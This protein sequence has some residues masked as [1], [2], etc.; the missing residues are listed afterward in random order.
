MVALHEQMS[1]RL[2]SECTCSEQLAGEC[3][4]RAYG[5]MMLSDDTIVHADTEAVEALRGPAE[6]WDGDQA[7]ELHDSAVS[8]T[9]HKYWEFLE[10]LSAGH[11]GDTHHY[12]V[13]RRAEDG[14]V[15]WIQA[16]IHSMHTSAGQLLHMWHVRDITSA[17]RCLEMSQTPNEGDLMLSLEDDGLPHSALLTQVPDVCSSSDP[18]VRSQLASILSAVVAAETFAVLHLTSFGAVDTVFPRRMFGW[19][20]NDLLDRSFISLLCPEDRVFF[21]RA[22]RRCHRD[23]IPQRLVLKLAS[24]FVPSTALYVDCDVT[25]LMPEAVQQPVLIVRATDLPSQP[26]RSDTLCRQSSAHVVRRVQMDCASVQATEVASPVGT[27]CVENCTDSAVGKVSGL[28]LPP[29]PGSERMLASL[30]DAT[31]FVPATCCPPSIVA[32]PTLVETTLEPT[33]E[34]TVEPASQLLGLY[35]GIGQALAAISISKGPEPTTRP[36]CNSAQQ[37]QPPFCLPTSICT[38]LVSP[39]LPVRTN[40]ETTIVALNVEASNRACI[41]I[42]M[43][44]IFNAQVMLPLTIANRSKAHTGFSAETA[45]GQFSP[46]STTLTSMLERFSSSLDMSRSNSTQSLC[47]ESP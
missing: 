20:E 29:S 43:C 26:G 42:P 27:Q 16:C 18:N 21:C 13:I 44:E 39:T 5:V 32:A 40:T 15:C 23:G 17:A 33:V 7:R 8:G 34:Q 38:G 4:L 19:S 1:A 36:I 10:R 12:F 41:D 22:L 45:Y 30:D 46:A 28:S 11:D 3:H 2:R 35:G 25:V 47:A 14:A 31:S 37:R 9:V 6:E 24:G